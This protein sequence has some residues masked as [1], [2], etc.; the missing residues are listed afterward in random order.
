MDRD[1]VSLRVPGPQ[2]LGFT[3]RIVANDLVGRLKDLGCRPVILL[4]P[5]DQ[6]VLEILFKI[7]D[8][9]DVSPSETVNGLIVVAYHAQVAVF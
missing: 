2:G 1:V 8:I 9:A 6:R 5:D 3:L 4:Q 7:Q